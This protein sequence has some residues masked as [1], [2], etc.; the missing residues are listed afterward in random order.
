MET[1]QKL[2]ADESLAQPLCQKILDLIGDL[3]SSSLQQEPVGTGCALLHC[4]IL[5]EQ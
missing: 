2:F 1:L 5:P 4:G 3:S